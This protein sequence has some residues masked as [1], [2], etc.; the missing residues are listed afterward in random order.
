M[1]HISLDGIRTP[2]ATEEQSLAEGSFRINS[3]RASRVTN[4][5]LANFLTKY[6][7]AILEFMCQNL[8]LY[9]HWLPRYEQ[10]SM[11]GSDIFWRDYDVAHIN[12]K[13]KS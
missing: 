7:M 2:E 11:G 12:G 6:S 10:F 3:T 1:P 9:S 13:F 8:A 4:F 5:D